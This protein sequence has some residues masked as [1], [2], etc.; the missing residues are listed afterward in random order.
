PGFNDSDGELNEVAS[1]I[2]EISVDIPWHVT[3]FRPEYHMNEP[4]PTPVST[5]LRAAEIGRSRG[6]RYVY[7]GN[8]PG[9]VEG[10]ENTV[11]P[12]C[13]MTL[14]ERQGF[15]ILANHLDGDRCPA[16]DIVIAGR[17]ITG[18]THL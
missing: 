4:E 7:A 5:L 17:W 9:R 13:D 18:S 10:T 11:C 14:I 3:A 15:T 6:L 1:F 12:S 16:C 2:A 8:M